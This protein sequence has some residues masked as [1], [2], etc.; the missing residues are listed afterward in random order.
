MA[1]MVKRPAHLSLLAGGTPPVRATRPQRVSAPKSDP[2]A[3]Q[4]P[5]APITPPSVDPFVMAVT[6]VRELAKDARGRN[7]DLAASAQQVADAAIAVLQGL[8]LGIVFDEKAIEIVRGASDQLR[9]NIAALW[10][11][12]IKAAARFM[13]KHSKL[14]RRDIAMTAIFSVSEKAPPEH[15]ERL[16]GLVHP[17]QVDATADLLSKCTSGPSKRGKN[18]ARQWQAIAVE[19]M[20]RAGIMPAP[21]TKK[22]RRSAEGKLAYHAGDVITRAPRERSPGRLTSP[23]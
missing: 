12:E 21:L 4:V 20:I 5:P 16:R 10:R 6:S 3:A 1:A 19:L 2:A 7:P 23:G 13:K 18:S 17:D 14:P 22:E 9:G 8:R 11:G 15:R